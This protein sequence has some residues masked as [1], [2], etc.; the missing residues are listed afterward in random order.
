[1]QL[2]HAGKHTLVHQGLSPALTGIFGLRLKAALLIGSLR[3]GYLW[4]FWCLLFVGDRSRY[5]DCWDGMSWRGWRWLERGLQHEY[6][7]RTG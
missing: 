2:G 6:V 3:W 4:W 7:G 5:F 1:M